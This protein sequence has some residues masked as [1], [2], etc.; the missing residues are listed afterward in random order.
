MR[1][2]GNFTGGVTTTKNN[3]N[4]TDGDQVSIKGVFSTEANDECNRLV[5]GKANIL[6]IGANNVRKSTNENVQTLYTLT[7]KIV[8]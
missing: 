1:G 6:D 7:K 3:W 8:K 2:K 4:L 5:R